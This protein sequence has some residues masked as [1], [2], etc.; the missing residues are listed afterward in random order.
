MSSSRSGG[1]LRVAIIGCGKIATRFHAPSFARLPGCRIVAACD[2]AIDNARSLGDLYGVPAYRDV[3]ECL[4]REGV[5]IADVVTREQDRCPVLE[6]CFAQGVHVFT[7]K[8]LAGAAGQY[9]IQDTDLPEAR[10]AIDAW[11]RAGVRFGVNLALR[12]DLAAGE[13]KRAVLAGELGE[14][15]ALCADHA[16]GSA[17]HLVDL[18]RWING[19]V[20]EVAG[21]TVGDPVRPSRA[22]FLRFDN[23]SVGTL[24]SILESDVYFR[25]QYAGTAGRAVLHN[26][27]GYLEW[28]D[29]DGRTAHSWRPSYEDTHTTLTG[30]FDRSIAAFVEDVRSGTEVVASGLDALRQMEVDAAITRSFASGRRERVERYQTAGLGEPA[31]A[32]AAGR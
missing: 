30:L 11:L 22:A 12:H 23:G 16:L 8:P 2:V 20:C 24:A 9:R 5:D 3:D 1:I 19:D 7:E 26:I 15:V 25:L 18:L 13:L 17:N 28:F 4:E 29:R 10:A 6:Q 31:R 21:V 27:G 14:P 32:G